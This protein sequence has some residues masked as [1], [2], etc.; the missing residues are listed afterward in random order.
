MLKQDSNDPF[1]FRDA[2]L[3]FQNRA[4]QYH[5]QVLASRF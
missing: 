3:L 2:F 5:I 4:G 1:L